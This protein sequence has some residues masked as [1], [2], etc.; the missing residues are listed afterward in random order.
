[1]AKGTTGHLESE[2]NT[3]WSLCLGAFYY[4]WRETLGVLHADQNSVEVV[5]ASCP[6]QVQQL[7]L[8]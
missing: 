1:M 5:E 7:R 3:V 8:W 2:S 6:V 4:L